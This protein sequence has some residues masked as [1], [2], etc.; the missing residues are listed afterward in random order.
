MT[1]FI[2]AR[3]GHPMPHDLESCPLYGGE[4]EVAP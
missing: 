1:K 2:L 3:G 4:Q